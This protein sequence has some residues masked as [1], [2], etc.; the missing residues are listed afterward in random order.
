[1]NITEYGLIGEKLPH[2]YSAEIHAL[3]GDYDY[4]LCELSKE[5]LPEF[6]QRKAFRGINVTIP[7]KKDVIPFLFRLD[8]KAEKI[9]AVNTVVNRDGKLYGY[10]TDYY[11]LSSLFSRIG[12]DPKGK[13]ALILGTGGTSRTALAVL[14]DSGA[15]RITVA[16]RTERDGAVTY[17][18]A[19]ELID[20][21]ILVNTTPVGM[22]PNPDGCPIDI[23]RFPRLCGVVDAVYNPLRTNLV[24]AARERG[25]PSIGGLYMLVAQAQAANRLFFGKEPCEDKATIEQVTDTVRRAK[26]NI[27][28]TGMPTSGKSSIGKLLS[29][30]T[31]RSFLD[32]DLVFEEKQGISPAEFIRQNGEEAFRRKESEILSYCANR[33]GAIIATGGGAVL[34]SENRLILSRN[35]TIV[36]IDRSLEKLSCCGDRP[37]SATRDALKTLYDTRYRLYREFCDIRVDGDGTVE[38]TAENVLNEFNAYKEGF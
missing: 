34:R 27:V 28:L 9:G 15:A 35:G 18:K 21:E 31:G 19:K 16:S 36:F 5:E 17:E 38:D 14:R 10:N 30:K 4:R 11:G 8:E 6:M 7:Y 26:E 13:N 12:I 24:S 25:I 1:M 3:L 2:S 20:T 29:E 23:S 33:S 32:A 22:Y 37:L